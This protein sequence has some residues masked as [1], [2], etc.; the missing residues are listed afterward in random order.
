VFLFPLTSL[1]SVQDG[2]IEDLSWCESQGHEGITVLD[3]N[4]KYSYGLLQFQL[5]TFMGFGKLYG[6]LP[7]EFTDNEGLLLIHNAHVQRAIAKEMLNDG[8]ERHWL[9]CVKQIGSY[10]L[11]SP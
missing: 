10:P 8:L 5:A 7:L 4:N 6:I 2:W 1:A 3:T 11:P 9:N